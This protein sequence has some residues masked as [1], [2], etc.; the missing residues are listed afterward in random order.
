MPRV[1]IIVLKPQKDKIGE[2]IALLRKSHSTLLKFGIVTARE[3]ILAMSSEG[4]IIQ[5]LEWTSKQA[6]E[7]AAVHDEVRE[8]WMEAERLCEFQK[9][10]EVNE[11][12]QMFPSFEIINQ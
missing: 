4:S 5:I 8:L 3:Q 9:P 1:A 12:T 2:L 6:E 7:E 11:F 10:I